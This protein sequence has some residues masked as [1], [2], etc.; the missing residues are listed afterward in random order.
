MKLNPAKVELL[1]NEEV[2]AMFDN[3]NEHKL[4]DKLL[5]FAFPF[6]DSPI[7]YSHLYFF[8]GLEAVS[9]CRPS[10]EFDSF[11]NIHPTGGRLWTATNS[12]NYLTKLPVMPVSWFYK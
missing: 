2:I 11:V 5:R 9:I 8:A 4:L 3:I 12:L 1:A 10:L 7:L 6:D